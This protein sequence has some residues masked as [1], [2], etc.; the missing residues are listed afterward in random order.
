MSKLAERL[1][2]AA[3]RQREIN[4]DVDEIVK[5]QAFAEEVARYGVEAAKAFVLLTLQALAASAATE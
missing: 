4:A 2:A 3:Q 5:D 1:R